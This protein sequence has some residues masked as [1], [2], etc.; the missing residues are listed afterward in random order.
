MTLTDVIYL[1]LQ[2]HVL[3]DYTELETISKN[4]EYIDHLYYFIFGFGNLLLR[5]EIRESYFQDPKIL[6]IL[7][8][9]FSR[10]ATDIDKQ[11]D[12]SEAIV[13]NLPI[14]EPFVATFV[15]NFSNC[16][17]ASKETHVSP[18]FAYSSYEIYEFCKDI[19]KK[20]LNIIHVSA[21]IYNIYSCKVFNKH[22]PTSSTE[23]VS[24]SLIGISY[25]SDSKIKGAL[26]NKFLKGNKEP[27]IF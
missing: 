8:T 2:A 19:Q 18:L 13:S 3:N 6:E 16:H 17:A 4:K 23:E 26:L 1:N 10:I 25:A 11:S 5:N 24:A 20:T 7:N 14:F 22:V 15:F 9:I 21:L 27:A 12:V